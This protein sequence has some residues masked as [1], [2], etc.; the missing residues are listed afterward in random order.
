[1]KKKKWQETFYFDRGNNHVENRAGILYNDTRRP[2][3]R[4]VAQLGSA[5]VLERGSPKPDVVGSNP[6]ER[7]SESADPIT[8][9]LFFKEIVK[10]IVPFSILEEQ[11]PTNTLTLT[12]DSKTLIAHNIS[13]EKKRKEERT[14][15]DRSR[16]E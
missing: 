11:R 1:T 8:G 15:A 10:K 13:N 12:Y 7:D 3:E 4:D 16:L 2:I 5:L 14:E 9:Q 6:T